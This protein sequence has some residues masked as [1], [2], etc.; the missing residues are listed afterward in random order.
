ML[1]YRTSFNASSRHISHHFD[2]AHQK[3]CV[4][5]SNRALISHCLLFRILDIVSDAPSFAKLPVD[6]FTDLFV[7]P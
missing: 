1:F 4:K 5:H 7:K 2:E 3:K 6:K